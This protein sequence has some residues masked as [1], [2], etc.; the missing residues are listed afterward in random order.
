MELGLAPLVAP[1]VADVVS[2]G[3]TAVGKTASL[4][5]GVE[6]VAGEAV[7]GVEGV[8]AVAGVEGVEAVVGIS[9]VTIAV[10]MGTVV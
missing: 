8:E 9:E 6:A 2:D 10:V 3:A 4:V 1:L 5:A 7:A